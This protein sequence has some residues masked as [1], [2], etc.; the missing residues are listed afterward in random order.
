[1]GIVGGGDRVSPGAL[2]A[3]ERLGE[4][5]AE[6]GWVLLN[7]GRAA[8]VMEASARGARRKG[9][10]VVGVLPFRSARE[11]AVSEHLDLAL[12][13]GLGDAR[14]AVN[15]LSSDVV[16]ALEGGEGTASE[17]ALALKGGKPV[18]LLGFDDKGLFSKGPR[19]ARVRTAAT[20]EEAVEV[21]AEFLSGS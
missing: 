11:G 12:F 5:V 6:R 2:R 3:A 21:A 20:P 14:N 10:L 8:G 15:A 9:G 16:I 1:M 18:I 4:L 7:G 17:M 19:A 13:T